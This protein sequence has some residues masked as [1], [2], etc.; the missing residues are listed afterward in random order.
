MRLTAKNTSL[1]AFFREIMAALGVLALI[2]LGFAHQP[3]A[4]DPSGQTAF[5]DS[6]SVVFCGS[7]P[8]EAPNA[9][10]KGCEACR[11]AAGIALPAPPCARA[12]RM[13]SPGI[14]ADTIPAAPVLRLFLSANPRAPPVTV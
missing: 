14:F 2:F 1:R 3:L 7:G 4:S 11:I 12:E 10:K 8:A 9:G 6:L 5:A 13:A